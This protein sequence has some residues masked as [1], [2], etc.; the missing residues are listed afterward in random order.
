MFVCVCV[1]V[2]ACMYVFIYISIC[3]DGSVF[4][5]PQSLRYI[6]VW[7]FPLAHVVGLVGGCSVVVCLWVVG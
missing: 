3:G 7:N 2:C 5:G 4:L 6:C 1:C